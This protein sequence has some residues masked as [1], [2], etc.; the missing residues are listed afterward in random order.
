MNR[1]CSV[2]FVAALSAQLAAAIVVTPL[3]SILTI[4]LF[5]DEGDPIASDGQTGNATLAAGGRIAGDGYD[6]AGAITSTGAYGVAGSNNVTDSDLEI[7]ANVRYEITNDSASPVALEVDFVVNG[8]VFSLPSADLG[9][10]IRFIIAL[11]RD[12]SSALIDGPGVGGTIRGSDDFIPFFEDSPF[13]GLVGGDDGDPDTFYQYVVEPQIVTFDAGVL[14]PGATTRITQLFELRA[15]IGSVE[16]FEFRFADPLDVNGV[17]LGGGSGAPSVRATPVNAVPLPAS[18]ALLLG[19][20]G[21]LALAR[22]S[23]G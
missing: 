3:D 20:V 6:V 7:N 1:L 13:G 12:G 16:F 17:P 15:D 22:R 9:T 10:E 8:G 21:A 18:A 2:I 5:D 23:R 14:A 19:G 4:S 11:G